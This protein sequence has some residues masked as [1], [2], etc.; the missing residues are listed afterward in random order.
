MNEDSVPEGIPV[1]NGGEAR[2][3][4]VVAALV[5]VV[6]HLFLSD[7]AQVIGFIGFVFDVVEREQG[8]GGGHDGVAIAQVRLVAQLVA[9]LVRQQAPQR[10]RAA[11]RLHRRRYRRRWRVR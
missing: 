5:G 6:L 1:V 3:A 8:G 11:Q 4:L 10:R 2:V 7:D 9:Q